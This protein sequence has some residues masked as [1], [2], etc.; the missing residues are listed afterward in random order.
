MIQR[1]AGKQAESVRLAGLDHAIVIWEGAVRS[2]KTVCSI[3]AWL[4][5][6]RVGPKGPLLMVGKTERTLRRNIIEPMIDMVGAKRCKANWGEGELVLFGRRVY[7]VG[8]NDE[9][10]QDKI[11]GMTLAG[12]YVDE[13]SLLPESFF[14]MLVTRLS[15]DGAKL[16][17]STNPDNPGHWLMRDYLR[18]ARTWL[19]HDGAII[20][21]AAL[22]DETPTIDVVRM[23]FRLAD[24]PTLPARFVANLEAQFVGLYRRRFI[25]GEWCV[26]EGSIFDMLDRAAGGPHVVTRAPRPSSVQFHAVA[27]DYATASVFSA[28]LY[29]ITLERIVCIGEWRWDARAKGTQRTDA[30]LAEGLRTWVSSQNVEPSFVVV[31]PAATSFIRQLHYDGWPSVT[32]ADNA[33]N[34]GIRSVATLL[35]ARR[36]PSSSGGERSRLQFLAARCT[37]GLDEMSNYVWDEK[38][39]KAGEDKPVKRDDHF[40]DQLRYLVMDYRVR[41]VWRAWVTDTALA[42]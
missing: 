12:A 15:V 24:N 26:A 9:R 3:I 36:E 33:V 8:A 20:E 32:L 6:V 39:A 23:S 25:E 41:N 14:A 27:I 40:P 5:Y 13:V 2:S 34:D 16:F 29:A 4:I 10:A 18:R 31:D 19:R 21:S 35:A 30:Q 11:R 28:G 1:L 37:P 38:A 7:L 17:G 42:A 22:D